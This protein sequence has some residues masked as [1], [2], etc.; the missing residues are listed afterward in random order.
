MYVYTQLGAQHSK[1]LSRKFGMNVYIAG[2]SYRNFS[3]SRYVEEVIEV[4][5]ID[6]GNFIFSSRSRR[7][8]MMS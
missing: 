3:T 7:R 8:Q 2:E 4:D 6:Q 5:E 1:K